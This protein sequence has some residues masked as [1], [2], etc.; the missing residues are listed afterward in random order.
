[1]TS[2]F[3]DL[4]DFFDGSL[5]LPIGG[6][7]YTVP[8]VSAV[9][10]LW[11]QSLLDVTTKAQ[12]GGDVTDAA[13]KL[14]DDD[15]RNLYQR[16]LGSAYEKMIADGVDWPSI[17]RAGQTAFVFLT[18]GEDAAV[19]FWEGGSGNAPAPNREERRKVSK[20]SGSK[21]RRRASTAGTTPRKKA[22]SPGGTSSPTGP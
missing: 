2:Q 5:R 9:D 6:V 1:M 16:M 7:T 11:A 13:G 17:A 14:D 20:G 15:E 12:A 21:T 8:P 19:K 18:M 3:A 10:G 4:R 22:A